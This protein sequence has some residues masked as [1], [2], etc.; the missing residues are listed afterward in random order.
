[1][2]TATLAAFTALLL[3]SAA[4]ADTAAPL[5]QAQDRAAVDQALALVAKDYV[6]PDKRAAIVAAVKK[7]E[8]EGRYDIAN[9]AE[10]AQML[11]DDL[12][13]AANDKHM[14]FRFDPAEYNART[15]PKAANAPD[16]NERAYFHDV[17]ARQNQ[18]Y[19]EMRILP[20]NV[21]YLKVTGFEWDGDRTVQ[22]AADAARFLS[23]GDAIIIDIAGNGGGDPRAVQALVSYLLPPDNRLLMTFYDTLTN[24]A[25]STRVVTKLGGPRLTGKPIYV[26]TSSA[27]GSAAEEFAYHIR[28]FDIGTL[29]G[30]TTGGAANRDTLFPIA[31]Y[32][33]QSISTGRTEHAV[34]HVNWEGTGVP[35]DI[36]ASRE[37]ALAT[38]EEAALK[39]L[40]AN[41]SAAHRA[42]YRWAL[43]GVQAEMHPMVLDPTTL[44]AYSGH[45]EGERKVWFEDGRLRYR[46]G[47]RE[48][49][50]LSA[51]GD[52]IF[53]F[54]NTENS[55]LHFQRE[56][57]KIQGF[58][59]L[60]D[61]GQT[62]PVKRTGD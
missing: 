6:F 58:E 36:Q 51:L 20:G 53:A 50:M 62:V 61:D 23:G 21:R 15:A 30:T 2:K 42:E 19:G 8:E 39:G 48:P 38:A 41:G 44:A 37:T 31:P 26:L 14:W 47:D 45:Y 5:T 9:P 11:S 28:A 32:F 12:V 27:T 22:A 29:V 54:G 34:T 17:S 56:N 10:F 57:G 46:R 18:G 24:T 16:D 33:V 4:Y 25:S 59:I 60:S 49:T 7:H 55:R 3:T 13:A 35:P 1:M 52:D 43:A 40:L